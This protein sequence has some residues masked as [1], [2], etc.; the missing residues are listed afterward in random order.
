MGGVQKEA[1]RCAR[2]EFE[3]GEADNCSRQDAAEPER[4]KQ[5]NALK[6]YERIAAWRAGLEKAL[7]ELRV[8]F[9]LS[10]TTISLTPTQLILDVALPRYLERVVPR[11]AIVSTVV[12]QRPMQRVFGCG[13]VILL[14]S[15]RSRVYLHNVACPHEIA[16]SVTRS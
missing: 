9:Y 12:R 10:L 2:G 15:D 16:R 5:R 1:G 4:E 14:L 13:D 3:T 11:A 8:A 7:Q 6:C